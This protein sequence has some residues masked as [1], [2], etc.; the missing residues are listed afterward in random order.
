MK[1][2]FSQ[3]YCFCD[4]GTGTNASYY[5]KREN[6]ELYNGIPNKP[7]MIINTEWGNFGADG[8]LNDIMTEFDRQL[9][10]ASLRPGSET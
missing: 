1:F 2:K 9:D 10:T 4:S 7:G 3:F 6:I 8:S 5:E